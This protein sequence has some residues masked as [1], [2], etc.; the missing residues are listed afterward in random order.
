MI[1]EVIVFTYGDSN[2]ISTWSNVPYLFT[3]TLERKGVIVHR[4]NINV[5]A[6]WWVGQIWNRILKPIINWLWP[7]NMYWYQKTPI[8]NKQVESIIKNAVTKYSTADYCI[9]M[10]YDYYNKHN[11]I[12]SILYCDVTFEMEKI[13]RRKQRPMFLE[14][15]LIRAQHESIT[16]SKLVVPL[17]KKPAQE[18]VAKGYTNIRC[19]EHYVI[20]KLYDEPLDA[21]KIIAQKKKS[22]KILFIGNKTTYYHGAL[23]LIDAFRKLKSSN[24]ELE[25]HIVAMT[26]N[27]FESLPEGVICHGYLHKDVEEERTLYYNLLLDARIICNPTPKW[28]GISSIMEAMYFFTPFIIAPFDDFKEYIGEFLDCGYFNDEFEANHLADNIQ[29]MLVAPN[30]EQMARRGHDHVKNY[31]WDNFI[32]WFITEVDTLE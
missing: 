18:L 30:Y 6:G 22:S 27:D 8:A 5:Y 20:N 2:D 12:P 19:C 23:M 25:L 3:K 31:T 10:T 11:N 32:D 24:P 17:F 26:A 1:K 13:G 15:A 9:F 14:K 7:Q 29:R 28:A 21:D 16:H 4:I